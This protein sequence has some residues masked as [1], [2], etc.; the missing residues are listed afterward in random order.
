M[1]KFKLEKELLKI[2]KAL[3]SYKLFFEQN[4]AT[5]D[6]LYKTILE[7]IR[8]VE[9]SNTTLL[10]NEVPSPCNKIRA[11]YISDPNISNDPKQIII[12]DRG[13]LLRPSRK[14]AR[15][16]FL[17]RK[18]LLA[19]LKCINQ[20]ERLTDENFTLSI[21]NGILI[22]NSANNRYRFEG[23]TIID[24]L[25]IIPSCLENGLDFSNGEFRDRKTLQKLIGDLRAKRLLYSQK[26]QA[27]E[28]KM[29]L[30]RANISSLLVTQE[31]INELQALSELYQGE[32]KDKRKESIC[33]SI[34]ILHTTRNDHYRIQ[35]NDTVYQALTFNG[36]EEIQ[37]AADWGADGRYTLLEKEL[38]E[39]FEKSTKRVESTG[40]PNILKEHEGEVEENKYVVDEVDLP[41]AVQGEGDEEPIDLNDIDQG[42]LGDCYYLSSI[43]AVAKDY[44][45]LFTKGA[46]GSIVKEKADKYIV[47]LH[48]RTDR[49]SLERRPV[50]VKVSKKS[51]TDKAGNPIYAGKSD[52][53]LWVILLERALAQEMG[54]FDNIVG[55]QPENAMEMLTG[56]SAHTLQFADL[57]GSTREQTDYLLEQLRRA[58]EANYPVTFSSKGR[59]ETPKDIVD[60]DGNGVTLFGGHAYTFEKLTNSVVH[61]YNPHGK[62]HLKL[63]MNTLLR[64]FRSASVLA[65]QK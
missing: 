34:N 40:E 56:K 46:E 30:V 2:K 20:D 61:L 54:N 32:N 24:T 26:R 63:N 36:V 11:K 59:G 8:L 27:L 16:L 31:D 10:S 12:I 45:E 38:L 49:N 4:N 51:L 47:T 55:G 60:A 37:M 5:E 19:R 43:G 22:V 39:A 42:A 50:E 28:N 3:K 35:K 1:S 18:E 41:Y 62:A 33:N 6:E 52:G 48:L 21:S 53:E 9:K 7:K 65:L 17:A 25:G 44:P 57:E 58:E 13:S 29:E 15:D 64:E 14:A 23:N